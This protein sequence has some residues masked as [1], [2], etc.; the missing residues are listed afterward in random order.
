MSRGT[1]TFSL[2]SGV[3]AFRTEGT[4]LVTGHGGETEENASGICHDL[5]DEGWGLTTSEEFRHVI[6]IRRRV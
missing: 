5:H 3:T 6:W 1:K 2:S 4:N